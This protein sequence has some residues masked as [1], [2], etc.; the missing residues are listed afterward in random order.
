MSNE[1]VRALENAAKQV[2]EALG[3][4]AKGAERR[5]LHSTADNLERSAASHVENDA[6]AAREL[7][8]AARGDGSVRA[9]HGA[10]APAPTTSSAG[11]S[12]GANLRHDLA[13]AADL[14]NPGRPLSAEEYPYLQPPSSDLEAEAVAGSR[15]PS[16]RHLVSDPG[17]RPVPTREDLTSFNGPVAPTTVQPGETIY[18]VVG[19]GTWP[20]GG[21]WSRTPPASESELRSDYAVLNEW[22]GDHGVVAYTPTEPIR[23]WEGEVAAQYASGGDDSHYLP[24]GAQQIWIPRGSVSGENGHWV[25]AP[26]PGGSTP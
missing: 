10:D 13:D 24:G 16:A 25:I 18:R 2:V 22:N 14:P 7:E 4:G 12:S 20:T 26:M 23:V 17:D 6:K 5:L 21:F 11:P 15:P 19:D 3:K 9:P 8:D 1:I